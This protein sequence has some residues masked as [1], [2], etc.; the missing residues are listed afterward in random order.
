MSWKVL[1]IY[2]SSSSQNNI[3]LLSEGNT[4]NLENTQ[5]KNND[6]K[7]MPNFELESDPDFV[8]QL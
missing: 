8:N 5:N 6:I 1:K 7:K 2:I 4:I 3:N